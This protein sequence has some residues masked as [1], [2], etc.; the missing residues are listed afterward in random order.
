MLDAAAVGAGACGGGYGFFWLACEETVI[1]YPWGWGL[2]IA[3][4]LAMTLLIGW[5]VVAGISS[6]YAR[7]AMRALR[8]VSIAL[9]L[10]T[11]GLAAGLRSRGEDA[12]VDVGSHSS[13][14]RPASWWDEGRE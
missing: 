10:L 3:P 13:M 9:G 6:M 2:A 4:P 5:L 1:R 11:I 14:F 7:P 8:A 12:I